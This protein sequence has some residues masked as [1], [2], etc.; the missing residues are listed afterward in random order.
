MYFHKLFINTYIGL[1]AHL[2]SLILVGTKVFNYT[3]KVDIEVFLRCAIIGQ[4]CG[5][6]F[7]C[8]DGDST[9]NQRRCNH[10]RQPGSGSILNFQ[11][12]LGYQVKLIL[13]GLV[14]YIYVVEDGQCQFFSYCQLSGLMS[15][16]N[17]MM[18]WACADGVG[19]LSVAQVWMETQ[20][21]T[22]QGQCNHG[23]WPETDVGQ[24]YSQ[25]A[26]CK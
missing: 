20:Q 22:S 8:M 15:A 11:E 21:Q 18:E 4:H 10:V 1:F 2:M 26:N 24:Q 19:S 9:T 3:Q 5:E 23:Q 13:K 6:Q 25:G 12:R 16:P 17:T 7:N 14:R